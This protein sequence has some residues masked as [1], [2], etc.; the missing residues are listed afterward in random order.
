MNFSFLLNN[1]VGFIR[2]RTHHV[3]IDITYL[4]IFRFGDQYYD[5]RSSFHVT[6][7]FK[8]RAIFCKQLTSTLSKSI[9]LTLRNE[10]KFSKGNKIT[11]IN[12]QLINLM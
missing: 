6:F 12:K 5:K 11:D 8:S 10:C 7:P 2:L 9:K 3:Y 1:L 4:S